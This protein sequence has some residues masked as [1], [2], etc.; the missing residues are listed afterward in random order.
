MVCLPVKVRQE[1]LRKYWLEQRVLVDRHVIS[2]HFTPHSPVVGVKRGGLYGSI[3]TPVSVAPDP[4]QSQAAV[5]LDW[6]ESERW[7]Y[8]VRCSSNS[9]TIS[10]LYFG[11]IV[12]TQWFLRRLTQME[13]HRHWSRTSS[14]SSTS[15]LSRS[16]AAAG[17][18]RS[19][20]Q[21]RGKLWYNF[22]LH[23]ENGSIYLMAREL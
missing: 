2:R 14:P 12:E 17:N 10:K 11:N 20:G 22:P 18:N 7:K 6:A 3:V 4:V 8:C 5:R 13:T 15:R 23:H 9:Q 21:I 1:L 16:F 19:E